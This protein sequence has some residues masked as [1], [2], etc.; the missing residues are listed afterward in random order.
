MANT[1]SQAEAIRDLLV[2]RLELF[3][4]SLDTSEGSALWSQVIEP[5]FEQLGTDPFD[6]DIRAFLKDRVTQSFPLISAQ[7]GDALVDLLITPLEVLLE[8]LKRE[9]Q[10]IRKGQSAR[11]PEQL[12]LE[13]A[14]DLAA[15][16]FVD[17]RSGSRSGGIVRVYFAAPTYLT[18]LPTT[19]FTTA[20]GLLFYPTA[21]LTV[22]PE[23][24][25][26]YRSGQEYY[27]DVSVASAESGTNYNIA[28][29]S[30]TGVTGISG[31]TRI[32]NLSGFEGG[33]DAETAE[34]LLARVRTSLAERTLNVR[35]GI[36]ARI[37]TDF[38]S[39]V[40][41]EV[42][43]YGDPEMTRDIVTGGGEG[44]VIASGVCFVVGQFVLMFSMFE[45]RGSDGS[46]AVSEGDEIEL[47]F[48]SFLYATETGSANE[49]FKIDTILFDSRNSITQMPSILLFRMNG[50]PSVTKP[51]AGTLPGVLP[52]VFAVVR[53]TGKIEISDIPGGILDPDTARG[54]I[55]INDGEVH[56]GG[57]YDVWLRAA[58]A[59]SDSTSFSS[60]RSETA[61]LEGEDLVV[62]GESDG[63]RHLLHRTYTVTSTTSFTLGLTLKCAA[64]GASG[65]IS[66]A[67][68]SG[69]LYTYELW[70]MSGVRFA[71]GDAVTDGSASGTV[72]AVSEQLWEDSGVTRGMTLSLPMGNEEGSYRIL[73]VDGPF[74]FVDIAL[75]TTAKDQLFRV[76]DE[77]HLD[78]FDPKSV[79]VPFGTAAP[80]TDLRTTIG[81]KTARVTINLQDFGVEVGDTLE[82]LTGDDA[83]TY[84]IDS[85]D[86]SYGGYGAVLSSAMSA[87]NSSL[88]YRV[89]RTQAAL[90]RPLLRVV[91]EGVVLLDSSGQDSGYK[92]PNAI[93]VDVRPVHAFSGAKEVSAGLNG[94][95][96][97]DP[98]S[99]WAP[100]A[101]YT[102]DIATYDW[103]GWT[104]GDFQSFYTEESFRRVYTDEALA[105]NGYIAIISVH[106][107]SGQMYLDSNLPAAAK[108]FLT[109]MRDWLLEVIT[110]FGFGGDE[111]ELVNAFS[112]LKFGPNT[113][114]A[115]PLLLQFEIIIPFE[116]F[117]GCNN[118]FVALPEFD[119][120]NEFEDSDTF[121]E[122]IGRF[123][124]GEMSGRD[125]ALLKASPGDVLTV[126]S[127]LNAGSYVIDSVQT[128]ALINARAVVDGGGAV[129]I[130]KAYKVGLVVI[131][132]EFPVPAFYG[133]EEFFKD[134][135]ATWSMP[136]VADLP[137]TVTDE[138]GSPVDGWTWVE[139]ALTWFFQT[140]NALGFDLP[141]GV[142][143]DVP[144][145]LKAFWQMLFSDY[146]V[147][148]PTAP[149][150]LRMYFQ[151]PTSCTV[152][153]PQVCARYSWAPPVHEVIAATGSP[154][155]LP[156]A[157]LD[158]LAVELEVESLAGSTTLS[159]TLTADA[160]TAETV[161]DL[162]A[163]LQTLLDPSGLTVVFSG[164]ATATGALTITTVAGGV[165]T[166]LYVTAASAADGFR[167]L[168]FY[169]AAGLEWA[170]VESTSAPD[171]LAK[172]LTVAASS[173]FALYATTDWS[174]L[175]VSTTLLTLSGTVG[176]FVD[177]EPITGGTSGATAYIKKS[178]TD[179][180]L[181]NISGTFAELEGITGGTS[182]ATATIS[183][184]TVPEFVDGETLTG[185][186]SAV[187][188]TASLFRTNVDVSV[189]TFDNDDV[190]TG[191]G[192]TARVQLTG[193]TALTLHD[194]TGTIT[195]GDAVT[196]APSGAVGVVEDVRQVI[197]VKD[198]SGAFTSGELLS[199]GTSGTA[200][201][202]WELTD[203]YIAQRNIEVTPGTN[204][205]FDEIADDLEA[206]IVTALQEYLVD[207]A[208][209]TLTFDDSSSVWAYTITLSGT[210]LVEFAI[211]G[212]ATFEAITT[213]LVTKLFGGNLSTTAS[214]TGVAAEPDNFYLA[215][216]SATVV[217]DATYTLATS[218]TYATACALDDV[219]EAAVGGDFDSLAVALNGLADAH[220]DGTRQLWFVG[221]S[222]LTV[223]T[224]QG[225][226]TTSLTLAATASDGYGLLGFPDPATDTGADA[227]GSAIVRG[228]TTPGETTAVYQHPHPPTLF[229]TA[230]GATELLFTAAEDADP[231]EVFP[232]RTSSSTA[233]SDL[234][235]DVIVGTPYD[236]QLA[237]EVT[238]S[239]SSY[240]APIELDIREESDWLYIYEQRRMLEHTDYTALDTDISGDRVVAVT[241]SFGSN[242]VS[243][244][245]LTSPE[246]TF[247]AP[248][249]DLE[250]DQVHV[251][252]V[253]FIEEGDD[254]GGY[255]VVARAATE[256][257]LDRNLT[258]STERIY[259]SGNDGVLVVD[260]TDAKVTSLT[261]AFTASDIG[262]YLT[263]W[264]SNRENTDGSYKIT[265]VEA[266]GSGCT[267]DTDVF[268]ETETDV[269]WAV[270][271]APTEAL[272]SSE[273][274]GRTALLGLRPI[275]VYS[276]EPSKLRIVSV[277]P[278][279]TRAEATVL[280]AL[281]E[282]N[283]VPKSG[284][285]QP[286]R[287]VRPGT[288]H[289]SSTLMSE[290]RE[291]GLYYFDVLAQSLGGS[292]VYNVPEDTKM[293]PVFGTY[294]SYG[295]RIDVADSRYTFSTR[296]EATMALTSVFLPA[297]LDDVLSNL[298][299]I[300][301]RS[302][303]I[304]YEFVPAVAQVQSTLSSETDRVL[305]ANALARHFLPSYVSLDVTYTGG[306]QPSTIA[307]A[308]QDYIDGLSAVSELDLSQLERILHNNAVTKYDHPIRL[309]TLT[310]DLDRRVV[311]TQ[312]EGVINDDNIAYN[313]TNRTTYFIAG[314]DASGYESEEDIP[315]GA[316]IRPVRGTT[317]ST[318]R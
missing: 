138:Y 251:G 313:G 281:D 141:S 176:V 291:Y 285:R 303:R 153:A 201:V 31:Y 94:F 279:L 290:Q 112:P 49:K 20:D 134:G 151:E 220:T 100:T 17:W 304:D 211:Q 218:F 95:V 288:Q 149:Q 317:K 240:A 113:D 93:P 117:D 205:T 185:G 60:I 314:A 14:R 104:G 269:H 235:R 123:N 305:C 12:R 252:D 51:V 282:D 243:L 300:N 214:L 109:S 268:P 253:L 5:V 101:D 261:A 202:L 276:S 277:T 295:Y 133:L 271:K 142:S 163:L 146:V 287:V 150:Y 284:V 167:W 255:T 35:R 198:A 244:V 274:S 156:L 6:T 301:A 212:A 26:L 289:A 21:G 259:R 15:N 46:K 197:V 206:L 199:G 128:Y 192:W 130:S 225:S 204:L 191:P 292:E 196:G 264:A 226:S 119:W 80:G 257:T 45:D 148:R 90:Q 34:E 22:R 39:I 188:G 302:V 53:T 161:E 187:T 79:L 298:V 183:T 125:P 118:V 238:F 169:D 136:A 68:V 147:G 258:A 103:P 173:G 158:G 174:R 25:L 18:L 71:V 221:G 249:T 160:G 7:D 127:G 155:T 9:I 190:I 237:V 162:A 266:D 145:T 75:T 84:T 152:Y 52:G 224:V 3:D 216:L 166:Y 157:E 239:D 126:V 62:S 89:Y 122:A 139:V 228:V 27:V 144:E 28:K 241:T 72:S 186:T 111:E 36:V 229:S 209:A 247:L 278:T 50:V 168:G 29:G 124:D 248:N 203:P 73:K 23:T 55:E 208:A 116:V 297:G 48:W 76:L 59:T 66:K 307:G 265:A 135:T 263:L 110:T 65:V 115:L 215:D 154:F 78:L 223:R 200:G 19:E 58:S 10:I 24:M 234:P 308:L 54:T 96:L 102:V 272:G 280:T 81:S 180:V 184:I 172:H 43:G 98:G 312:A 306:N 210:G 61:L 222:S 121:N 170:E 175:V 246:F 2:E 299:T 143:L 231:Y 273:I 91:P 219:I 242:V 1:G 254:T 11:Y 293:E 120:K 194:L 88:E 63:Y 310:H 217:A 227:T 33:A 74:L 140:L 267:L 67:S 294:D 108:D 256:L 275:R 311:G 171:Y 318:L 32:A 233:I 207:D 260:P 181:Y 85:W 132:D 16:F 40:D 99:G 70:E 232:G 315:A 8:P 195:L 13:D 82:I 114:T 38:P 213:S 245:S 42:V 44:S 164:P 106:G 178:G 129:D 179:L 283:G 56:I 131:R 230:V 41:V 30:I 165:D 286:Y 64:T 37:G 189:G 87:T 270:V 296:E 309:I 4:A 57:H 107:S 105:S 137:F 316:R 250:E 86:T 77:V 83:G 236:G 182:G 159:G 262:R 92:I 177:D 193:A 69:G 97:M 47:N